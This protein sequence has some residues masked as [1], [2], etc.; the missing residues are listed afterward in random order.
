M[1]LPLTLAACG[2]AASETG[3]AA[4]EPAGT[5]GSTSSP[6]PAKPGRTA[7]PSQPDLRRLET[8]GAG[9][10]SRSRFGANSATITNKWLPML[11]G[12]QWVFEGSTVEDGE[13]IDHSLVSTVTDLTKVVDGVRTAVLWERDFENGDPVE[14]EVAF[15]AQDT[16]GNVWELGEYPEEYEG[17]QVVDHPAWI[18]GFDGALAGIAMRARPVV[19]SR[20]YAEGL[21]PKVGWDDRGKVYRTGQRTC[22][23]TGCYSGVVVIDEFSKSEPG[24]HQYKYYAPGVGNV[25][26][27]FGGKDATKETLVLARHRKLGAADL[28]AGRRAA[29]TL[30]KHAYRAARS[31][32][33]GTEQMR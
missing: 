26:V 25:R 14:A 12:T 9:A 16:D 24:A 4:A 1:A 33:G 10:Y 30:E 7:S 21:G 23:P 13:R 18:T 11:P 19:R 15:F 8:V 28:S 17:S 5:A 2:P 20:D 31:A 6:P 27:G 22:V 3:G 32:Y 29:L